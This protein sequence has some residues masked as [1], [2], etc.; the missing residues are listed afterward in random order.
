MHFIINQ[1][2]AELDVRK[3]ILA[4]LAQMTE[5]FYQSVMVRLVIYQN[6]VENIIDI[7]I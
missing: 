3:S 4:E 5:E 7:N 1:A 6:D 2:I